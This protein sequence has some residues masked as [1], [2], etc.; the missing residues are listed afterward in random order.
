M[1]ILNGYDCK[2]GWKTEAAGGYPTTP[3]NAAYKEIPFVTSV[4]GSWQPQWISA[5][6][7]GRRTRRAAAVGKVDDSFSL[8][9]YLSDEATT[10]HTYDLVK[11]AG[12]DGTADQN[13]TELNF[14]ILIDTNRDGTFD[15]DVIYAYGCYIN[16]VTFSGSE[17]EAVKCSME[18]SVNRLNYETAVLQALHAYTSWTA[19]SAEGLVPYPDTDVTL[20]TL[21]DTNA[22]YMPSWSV[23]INNNRTKHWGHSSVYPNADEAGLFE[24]TGSLTK[25]FWGFESIVDIEA[26]TGG[27]AASTLVIDLVSSTYKITMTGVNFDSLSVDISEGEQMQQEINFTASTCSFAD[28]AA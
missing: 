27:T 21:S 7:L 2:L 20:A 17:G 10:E 13:N 8:E 15:D 16:S 24:V 9:F 18:L 11:L 3:T 23:T 6:G 26:G 4:S 1:V 14:I 5:T 19:T 22:D 25:D 28:V 12:F